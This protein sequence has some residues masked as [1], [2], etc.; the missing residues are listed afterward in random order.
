MRPYIVQ[1][2]E[3]MKSNSKGIDGILDFAYMGSSEYE[4]GA[5]P[6]SLRRIRETPS[7]YGFESFFVDG[8]NITVY[9][10][11]KDLIE[12]KPLIFAMS[13]LTY[14]CKERTLFDEYIQGKENKY[15]TADFWWDLENDFM[16]WKEDKVF[17]Q[18]FRDVI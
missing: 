9:G 4:W 15:E 7:A 16:F 1:R 18:S 17:E 10:K 12:I 3:F 6:Q 5:L 8:K 14:Q 13:K 11:I 2:A